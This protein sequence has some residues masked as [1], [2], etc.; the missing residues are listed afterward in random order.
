MR[1][2]GH[3]PNGRLRLEALLQVRWGTSFAI[4]RQDLTLTTSTTCYH[5]RR[6]RLK[7]EGQIIVYVKQNVAIGL[8]MPAWP[9]VPG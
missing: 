8:L 7:L 6:Q 1:S 9:A 4:E 5:P 2:G 3:G